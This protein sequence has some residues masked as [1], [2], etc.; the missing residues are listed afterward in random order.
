[1]P[2]VERNSI[3][4]GKKMDFAL[5]L[6]VK[7]TATNAMMTKSQRRSNEFTS[8]E[9]DIKKLSLVWESI[10]RKV[11]LYNHCILSSTV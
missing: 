3:S 5:G 7:R 8:W 2:K 10:T 9:S 6:N 4:T 11:S 1:M